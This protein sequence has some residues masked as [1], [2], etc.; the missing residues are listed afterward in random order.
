MIRVGYAGL[1]GSGKTSTARALAAHC[2]RIE[3][4][5]KVELISE[6]ARRYIAKYGVDTLADQYRIMQKQIEWE[7]A[8]PAEHTD[9]LIT[10]SPIHLGFIYALDLK[11]DTRKSVMYTNDIFK[12]LNKMNYPRR[13]DIVFY[14]P[15]ILDPVVD[16]IRDE[17]HFNEGWRG[18]AAQRIHATFDIFPPHMF[19]PL[20]RTSLEGRVDESIEHLKKYLEHDHEHRSA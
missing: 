20:N 10:D 3:Q 14:L 9:L 8:V 19:I 1:P 4:F 6:Y 5:K 18:K 13:Y 16:G 17:S 11:E 2:R 7:D 15:P 12:T